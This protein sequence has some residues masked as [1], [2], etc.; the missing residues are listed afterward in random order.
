MHVFELTEVLSTVPDVEVSVR[1]GALH[2]HV[3]ALGDTAELDP[4]DVD[5][6][7]SIFVP[8]RKAAVQLDVRRG[9]ELLP[10]IVTEGD[11]VFTPL[12]AQD[13]VERGAQ[14]TVPAM[15]GLIAYSEMHRDV[16]AFG[17]TVDAP[18]A[19][20]D[21]P[22]VAGTLLAHRCF[23]G[24]AVRMGLWPIR[25]AAWWEYAFAR[26]GGSAPTAAFR[27]DPIW[28]DLM[29]DVAE[30]RRRQAAEVSE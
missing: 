21:P 27:A 4:D 17:R 30:A 20:L 8:T 29:A 3:P 18:G 10:L 15:P 22:M 13:L 26:V 12:Y 2:V 5:A 9:R 19:T 1:R 24:G 11:L 16:R 25:V 23:V 7:A 28:D 14:V 6:A